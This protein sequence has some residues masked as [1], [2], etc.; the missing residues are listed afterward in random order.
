MLHG[1]AYYRRLEAQALIDL[2]SRSQPAIIA[3]PGGIVNNSEAYTLLKRQCV[4]IWLKARPEDHMKRVLAQ[5]DR[6]PMANRPNAMA[7]LG[8]IL[9]AREP[10][11][12]QSDLIVDTTNS[13]V[14]KVAEGALSALRRRGWSF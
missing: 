9:S 7:E 10:L 1:E 13:S 8:S 4:T 14:N 12:E 6:R 3:L 5:G 2:L 11:Y